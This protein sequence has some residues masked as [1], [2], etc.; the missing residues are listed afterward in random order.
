MKV[1]VTMIAEYD[2]DNLQSNMS[3]DEKNHIVLNKMD[4]LL[5]CGDVNLTQM[6]WEEDK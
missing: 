1:K 2:S 3:F 6:W 5:K 4:K